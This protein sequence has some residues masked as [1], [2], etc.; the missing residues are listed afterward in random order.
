MVVELLE[1]GH[2]L[3]RVAGHRSVPRH[4]RQAAPDAEGEPIGFGIQLCH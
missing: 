1:I 3:F 2:G 4:E